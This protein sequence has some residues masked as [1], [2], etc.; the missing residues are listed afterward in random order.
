MFVAGSKVKLLTAIGDHPPGSI[1][2]VVYDLGHEV[3]EVVLETGEHLT[4]GCEAL[5]LDEEAVA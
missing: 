1:G 4:L 5:C 3:C 2:Y